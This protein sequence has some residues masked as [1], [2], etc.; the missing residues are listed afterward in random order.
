MGAW[1]RTRSSRATSGVRETL[2]DALDA[3]RRLGRRARRALAMILKQL[4]SALEADL[5]SSRA[6]IAEALE[7]HR[8]LGL[9]DA[10]PLTALSVCEARAGDLNMALKHS[11]DALALARLS[12]YERIVALYWR[13]RYLVELPR[14]REAEKASRELLVLRASKILEFRLPGPWTYWQRSRF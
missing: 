4:A 3:A 2:K 9:S 12:S 10:Q 11:T 13:S 5:A 6:Y 14:W 8:E 7:V 1:S